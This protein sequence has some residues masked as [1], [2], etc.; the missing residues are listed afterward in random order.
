MEI[1]I[2]GLCLMAASGFLTLAL[3]RHAHGI[4]SIVLC[5]GSALILHACWPTLLGAPQ[6]THPLPAFGTA[7]T[8][9]SLS[10]L[11]IILCA[12]LSLLITLFGTGYRVHPERGYSLVAWGL[13]CGSITA[14]PSTTDAVMFLILWE[15]MTAASLVMIMAD[16]KSHEAASASSYYLAA[17]VI[18]S[19]LLMAGFGLGMAKSGSPLFQNMKAAMTLP[20]NSMAAGLFFALLASGF[21]LKSGIIPLHT[22][23]PRAHPAAPGHVSAIMSGLM[24]NAGTYGLVRVWSLTPSTNPGWI[25]VTLGLIT[26]LH[27]IFQGFSQKDFKRFLAFSTMENMG[28]IWA[29]LGLAMISEF[30][31]DSET[32]FLALSG[33]LGLTIVHSIAKS[34]LFM[35][36]GSLHS[37]YHTRNMDE[38]GGAFRDMP[39]QTSATALASMSMAGLPPFAGFAVEIC[40]ILA[41]FHA[42]VRSLGYISTQGGFASVIFMALGASALALAAGCSLAAFTRYFTVTSLG[43]QRK[44]FAKPARQSI[45]MILPMMICSLL[46]LA[47]GLFPHKMM[48][49]TF[50]AALNIMNSQGWSFSESSATPVPSSDETFTFMTL[51]H[52]RCASEYHRLQNSFRSWSQMSILF[53]FLA[54]SAIAARF[55][56]T[57]AGGKVKSETW[58]CGFSSGDS[59]MQYTASSFNQPFVSLAADSIGAVHHINSPHG[60]FP[61]SMSIESTISDPIETGISEPITEN[62]HRILEK[63]SWIQSGDTRRYILYGLVFLILMITFLLGGLQ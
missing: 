22:W 45:L 28:I 25:I 32:A 61:V 47:G 57:S 4:S 34:C 59:S 35:G 18:C 2:A 13:F 42:M 5:A 29:A 39:L 46:L 50:P 36:A 21:A 41:F 58:V 11:F 62:Y 7:L 3:R 8:I 27:G 54:G 38:L 60:P 30:R 43:V 52:K 1:Y 26:A 6:I 20:S 44:K 24:V 37:A 56:L 33:A 12:L 49:M 55:F 16:R 40:I 17:A 51:R 14:L 15:I 19:S 9:D 31:N 63:L 23:L 48:N 53:T 10:A